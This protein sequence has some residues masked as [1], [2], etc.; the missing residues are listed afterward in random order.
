[1]RISVFIIKIDKYV[2]DWDWIGNAPKNDITAADQRKYIEE[3]KRTAGSKSG[4]TLLIMAVL[5]MLSAVIYIMCGEF[6]LGLITASLVGYMW[7]QGKGYRWVYPI[8]SFICGAAAFVGWLSGAYPLGFIPDFAVNAISTAYTLSIPVNIIVG[9]V[10]L[11]SKKINAHI[12]L[13]E[14]LNK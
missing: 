10:F 8:G 4:L 12:E 1:M 13:V 9:L 14:Q 2:D 5:T 11:Y 6:I 7:Y 3:L